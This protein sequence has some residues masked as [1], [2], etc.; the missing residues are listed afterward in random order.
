MFELKHVFVEG[1]SAESVGKLNDHR[2]EFVF[3]QV[4]FHIIYAGGGDYHVIFLAGNPMIKGE[5]K[6]MS[7]IKLVESDAGV[8]AA[9]AFAIPSAL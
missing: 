4:G 7:M 2:F 5:V 1:I 9:E 3:R 8:I 6:R